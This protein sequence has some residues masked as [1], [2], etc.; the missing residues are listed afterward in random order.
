[1]PFIVASTTIIVLVVVGVIVLLLLAVGLLVWSVYNRLITL[2]QRY[3]N[4]VSQIGVQLQRRHDL[5]P[6]LVD[7]VKAYMSHEKTTLD[8]VI[9][10]RNECQMSLKNVT[11]NLGD[12]AAMKA[13]IGSENALTG[14]LS[15]LM[16]VKE[17]YP[18][19]KA[20]ENVM[21]L[22]EELTTT[23]N[24]IAFARQHYNDSATL[25]NTDKRKFPAVLIAAKLG[26]H[27]DAAMWELQDEAARQ[28][29][30]INMDP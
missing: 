9:A 23:E 1:M 20:N 22:Q 26:H 13:V 29:P 8:A 5:I 7:S 24:R 28:A 15:R 10:A 19:L 30:S 27:N 4:A 12:L 16:V 6:G 17:D 3:K 25:Y 2:Q 11:G 21:Q 18:E 14:F